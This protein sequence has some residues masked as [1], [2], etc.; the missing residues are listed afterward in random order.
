M[1]AARRHNRRAAFGKKI[2]TVKKFC[3]QVVFDEGNRMALSED[4]FV[5]KLRAVSQ[6]AADICALGPSPM[7]TV[8]AEERA[9]TIEGGLCVARR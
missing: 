4:N 8:I 6:R 3:V 2:M 7:V 9:E 5:R 1:H